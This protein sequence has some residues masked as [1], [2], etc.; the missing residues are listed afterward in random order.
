MKNS[1]FMLKNKFMVI[2]SKLE[3]LKTYK[4]CNIKSI[5]RL[6]KNEHEIMS[7][8]VSYTLLKAKQMLGVRPE[9]VEVSTRSLSS[10]RFPSDGIQAYPHCH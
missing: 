2:N 9:S 5:D 1:Y 3:T 7:S 6:L 8:S 4:F 10:K